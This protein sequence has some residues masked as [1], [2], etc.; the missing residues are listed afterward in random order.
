MD[1]LLVDGGE[2]ELLPAAGATWA[3]VAPVRLRL[4]SSH[5]IRCEGKSVVLEAN[6]LAAA[7]QAAGKSYTD[8]PYSVP[9]AVASVQL[10]V[11]QSTLSK[12]SNTGGGAVATAATTG[13]FEVVAAQKPAMTTSSPPDP[14]KSFPKKGEWK[15]V[16][17]NQR[18]AVSGKPAALGTAAAA[19][20]ASQLTAGGELEAKTEDRELT[21]VALELQDEE[22][23]PLAGHRVAITLPDGRR[24]ERRLNQKGAVRV[25]GIQK[26]GD[27]LVEWLGAPSV[28]LGPPLPPPG[29]WLALKVVDSAGEP[30][31]GCELNVAFP[32]GSGSRR[33]RTRA[34]GALRIEGVPQSGQCRVELLQPHELAVEREKPSCEVS[35]AFYTIREGDTLFSLARELFLLDAEG[36]LAHPKN[37]S[38]AAQSASGGILPKGQ[39]LY[40]PPEALSLGL[41]TSSRHSVTVRRPRAKLSLQLETPAGEPLAQCDW[42]LEFAEG[43]LRGTTDSEGR[44]E[45]ALPPEAGKRVSLAVWPAVA[46]GVPAGEPHRLVL[47]IGGLAPLSAVEGAQAR[48]KNLG[49]YSGEVDGRAGPQTSAAVKRFQRSQ[50]LPDEGTLTA[51]TQERLGGEYGC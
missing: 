18:V 37:Q 15:V 7:P 50:Q 21:W 38:I 27:C 36:L 8:G 5:P 13:T 34:G 6:L 43:P 22:G 20:A 3:W 11:D 16:N 19:A 51:E 2:I 1:D 32:N 45:A 44:L 29:E 39:R 31:P 41:A 23:E 12:T 24:L 48:L 33:C 47:D 49:F 42:A 17:T 30:L 40:L 25:S 46:P 9:G 14:D 35:G 28:P 26:A 4:E 10:K